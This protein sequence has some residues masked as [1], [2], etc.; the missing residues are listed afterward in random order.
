MEWGP[1]KPAEGICFETKCDLLSCTLAC[2]HTAISVLSPKNGYCFSRT[3]NTVEHSLSK[4]FS[5][6][7]LETVQHLKARLAL[8]QVQRQTVSWALCPLSS[9]AKCVITCSIFYPCQGS[10]PANKKSRKCLNLSLEKNKVHGVKS[11]VRLANCQSH[12][13]RF[14]FTVK[15][16]HCLPIKMH[17]LWSTCR[18]WRS[19]SDSFVC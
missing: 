7:H 5:L 10:I 8:H 14:T 11:L 13:Q 17:L 1:W 4:C 19:N 9:F 16:D 2:K 15:A 3:C 18:K 12:C 6:I